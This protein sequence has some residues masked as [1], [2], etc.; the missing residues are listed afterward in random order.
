MGTKRWKLPSGIEL[1]KSRE[2]ETI[3]VNFTYKG[4]RCREPLPLPVTQANIKYASNLRGEILNKIERNTFVYSEYFPKSPKIKIFSSMGKGTTVLTYLDTY[5]SNA[6]KRGL[7]TSTINGYKKDAST[8]KQFHKTLVSELTTNDLIKYVETSTNAPKTIRNRISLLKSA[9]E[10]AVAEETIFKNP[11][12]FRVALYLSKSEK[13]DTDQAHDDVDAFSHR[14]IQAILGKCTPEEKAI[15]EFWVNTGVRSSEWTALKWENVDLIHDE[16]MIKEAL[17]AK[18]LKAPK[19]KAGRRFIPLNEIAKNA[20]RVQKERTYLNGTY[21]FLNAKHQPW[22]HDTFRKHRWTKILKLAGVRYRKPYQLRHTFATRHIS[23]GMNLW[24]LAKTLG[25]SSPEMLF[26]HY[27][28][29]VEDYDKQK[30]QGESRTM[31]LR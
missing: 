17:V 2:N 24:K 26:R 27:G 21:V 22:N 18:E 6:E 8:L 30:T 13:T 23:E 11:A 20:L 31:N 16:V 12:N 9:L 4:M 5:I 7:A 29:F 28:N 19:T 3:R 10:R 25:H 14:E 1:R 15:V